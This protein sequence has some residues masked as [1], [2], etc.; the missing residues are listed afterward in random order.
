MGGNDGQAIG[1]LLL[2]RGWHLSGIDVW[3]F[4]FIVWC[5]VFSVWCFVFGI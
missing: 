4:V 3:C 2:F 1:I 5:L